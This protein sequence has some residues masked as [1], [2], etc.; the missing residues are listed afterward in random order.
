[1]KILS[2]I[3]P[4]DKE[5]VDYD[6]LVLN[7][8]KLVTSLSNEVLQLKST[9]QE[10]DSTIK[11]LMDELLIQNQTI[12]E[13]MPQA[14]SLTE[15]EMIEKIDKLKKQVKVKRWN[16]SYLNKEPEEN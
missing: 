12:R 15:T 6:F 3:Q 14:L 11:K 1:M 9:I 10:K 4:S 16:P 2:G 5:G 7:L 13:K 8:N